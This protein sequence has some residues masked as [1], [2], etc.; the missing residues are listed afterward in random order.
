MHPPTLKELDLVAPKHPVFLNGSYSGII[1][2]FAMKICR[3]SKSSKHPGILKDSKTGEPKGTIR[4]SVF[5][6][7]KQYIPNHK[8]TKE[9]EHD[10]LERML[11]RYNR[12]GFTSITDG[13]QHLWGIKIYRDLHAESRLPIRVCC[14]VEAPEFESRKQFAENLKKLDVCSRYGDEYVRIG[15]LKII[16]D[17]GILTGTA[18]MRQ[19]W[20]LKAKEIYGFEDQSYRGVCNYNQSQL[21]DIVSTANNLGW[22]MTA[23]CTGGGAVDMLLDAYEKANEEKAIRESRYS[24]IH[25]NFYTENAIERCQKLGVIADLQPAWFYK[26]G[27]AMKYILGD[28][29]IKKFLP[30]RTMLKSGMILNGGSDHMEKFDSYRAINPYNPFLAMWVA[31]SRKTER[32]IVISPSEGISREEALKMYTINNAYGTFEEQIKGSIE[33]GKF[34]DL[35]VISEN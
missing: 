22:K 5:P 3:I 30:L 32:G 21:Q 1:N 2:S 15:A 6:L 10:A 7:L 12:V 34:A 16:M 24:I 35:I 13:M 23:H 14:N 11:R 31:V 27:D 26:D 20:G 8:L 4:T 17:G 18:F 28:E 9:Q 33:V 25:G 19:P 29:R